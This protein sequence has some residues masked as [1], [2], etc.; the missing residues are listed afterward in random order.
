MGT[1]M[2]VMIADTRLES[3][4][5]LAEAVAGMRAISLGVCASDL[6]EAYHA[7]ES[8]PP[9]ALIVAEALAVLPEFEVILTLLKALDVRCVVLADSPASMKRLPIPTDQPGVAVTH[10]GISAEELRNCL[11]SVHLGRETKEQV[12]VQ[13]AGDLAFQQGRVIL[14]GAST[15]GVDALLNVLGAFPTNCPPTLVVQHTSGTFSAGL[16]RLLDRNVA[17]SVSEAQ[18]GQP[19]AP[20]SILLAPGKEHHL[21]LRLGSGLQCRLRTAPLQ[22][23]HRPSVDALFYSAVPVASRVTA[24]I[25]TG[26]GRDGADGLLALRRAGAE[27]IGQDAESSLVYGMPRAAHEIGAVARQLPLDQIGPALLRT[28]IGRSA[29]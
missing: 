1:Q 8:R 21:E 12:R 9:Q 17:P 15:G 26:M 16:S 2:R 24:A 20:G 23:G 5:Q 28:C 22:S 13:G 27:T 19:L 29:A 7:I 25:L 14:I 6:S 3:R 4:R 10:R 18:D 11:L